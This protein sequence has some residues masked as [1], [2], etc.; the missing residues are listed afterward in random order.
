[1]FIERIVASVTP[2]SA[3]QSI[4][5]TAV[6]GR[7]LETGQ[8]RARSYMPLQHGRT[9]MAED[10]I[11]R[12][13]SVIGAAPEWLAHYHVWDGNGNPSRSR[14]GHVGSRLSFYNIA[15]APKKQL[16]T[17][18]SGVQILYHDLLRAAFVCLGAALIDRIFC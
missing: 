3:E 14:L 9:A 4:T 1:M 2:A 10:L 12:S 16:W 5:P 7:A 18:P 13:G 6:S 15:C 17:W 11:A 8:E